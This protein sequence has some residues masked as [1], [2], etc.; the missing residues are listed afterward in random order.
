MPRMSRAVRVC[1]V[2]ANIKRHFIDGSVI[3]AMQPTDWTTV[4]PYI[5]PRIAIIDGMNSGDWRRTG[6]ASPRADAAMT[7]ATSSDTAARQL[8]ETLTLRLLSDFS[9]GDACRATSTDS[10]ALQLP[11]T[12][13]ETVDQTEAS[14]PPKAPAALLSTS[15][16][17]SPPPGELRRKSIMKIRRKPSV[18]KAARAKPAH[19]TVCIDIDRQQSTALSERQQ[20]TALSER[21]QSTALSERQQSTA[22][23][24]RQQSTALSERQQSTALSD[25]QL[26]TDQWLGASFSE[27]PRATSTDTEHIRH[28]APTGSPT[29]PP[30]PPRLTISQPKSFRKRKSSPRTSG[31]RGVTLDPSFLYSKQISDSASAFGSGSE[32]EQKTV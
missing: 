9:V 7:R 29:Q 8:S 24:E 32:G 1:A 14:S 25:R 6:G 18:R 13:T 27:V 5:G 23:S 21:Q 12:S 19:V 11:R 16:N 20:S 28:R 31:A 4:C 22:L 30:T 26:S 3:E 2:A 17:A 15:S 10:V